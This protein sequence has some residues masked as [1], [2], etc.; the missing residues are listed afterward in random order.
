MNEISS[1]RIKLS[2]ALVNK[3]LCHLPIL[4]A[5]LHIFTTVVL[6][7]EKNKSRD[8]FSSLRER[9]TSQRT[10]SR[11]SLAAIRTSRISIT[12]PKNRATAYPFLFPRR[13]ISIAYYARYF[14][15]SRVADKLN[16]KV[17][18][19]SYISLRLKKFVSLSLKK[20]S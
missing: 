2:L 16:R 11:I 3:L 15:P 13:S 14:S 1:T 6:H 4:K 5:T 7:K 19:R 9:L 17:D 20:K 12:Y 10:D 8:T 18:R